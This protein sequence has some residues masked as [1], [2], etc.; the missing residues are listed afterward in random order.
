MFNHE[1][2]TQGT[3]IMSSLMYLF[4]DLFSNKEDDSYHLPIVFGPI[5]HPIDS[6]Y[7]SLQK[8]RS[9]RYL[10]MPITINN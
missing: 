7:K 9:S 10:S 1:K 6:E 3:V 8:K 4:Q 2:G 5:L